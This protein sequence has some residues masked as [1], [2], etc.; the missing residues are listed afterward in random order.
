MDIVSDTHVAE[1]KHHQSPVG[2]SFVRQIYGAA[3]GAS[4]QAVFFSLSEYTRAAE[5]FAEA[6]AI[7]LFRYDP[8][9]RTLTAKSRSALLALQHGLHSGRNLNSR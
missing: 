5:E 1:V 9:R 3:T 8:E 7:L 6:N 4:K 2:V